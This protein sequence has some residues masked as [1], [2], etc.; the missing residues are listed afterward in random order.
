MGAFHFG[1]Q[2]YDAAVAEYEKANAINPAFSQPYN[3]KGYAYR[4]L[5]KYEEAEQAFKKYIE[6]IPN[7][8]NPYDSYA[9]LLMKTGRFEESIK[10]YEKAPSV[11]PNFVASYVGIGNARVFMGQGEEARKTYAKLAA[12]ARNDGERRQAHFWTAM[13]WVHEGAT[14][15]ALAELEKMAAID[16]A[17][18]DLVA[19]SGVTAQMGNVLIEAGRVDEAA[20]KYRERTVII[21]KAEVAAQVKEG[22]H[23]QA[24]FDEARVALARNDL[25]SA[26]A[27]AS[28]YSKAVTA[29][30]IPFEVRQSRELAGHIALAEK[31]YATAAAELR[32]ANQQDP[33]VLYLTAVALQGKGD[34][35][36]AK[37]VGIQAAEW[38]GLSNT[39]GYVRSKART[40]VSAAK[41]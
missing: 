37:E 14:D 34:S 8:P 18:K 19:L 30:G 24:L 3:Q 32:Q 13:S 23:R 26:K 36:S 17:G 21:D 28:A 6:L 15:K 7:D 41:D 11:D 22:A 16:R 1:R 31:D 2:D 40:L 10:S 38:N 39:Y 5:G 29:K 20:E 35:R 12:I 9:E 33:R 4:F 25:A 27:K